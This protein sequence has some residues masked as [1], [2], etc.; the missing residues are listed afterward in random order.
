MKAISLPVANIGNF[1]DKILPNG[2]IP[3]GNIIWIAPGKQ[4]NNTE[5]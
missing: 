5:R 2:I 3:N 1:C 4:E